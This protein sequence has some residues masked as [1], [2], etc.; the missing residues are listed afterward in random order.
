MKRWVFLKELSCQ[1]A[2]LPVSLFYLEE[3]QTTE[4]LWIK[5]MFSLKHGLYHSCLVEENVF[6]RKL[7]FKMN[8]CFQA[9]WYLGGR[10][11]STSLISRLAWARCWVPGQPGLHSRIPV[12]RTN[13]PFCVV[14]V[15]NPS[16]CEIE[17][18]GLSWLQDQTCQVYKDMV[19]HDN[20]K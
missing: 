4:C 17:T 3:I 18:G 12:S 7:Y 11:R 20:N 10:G 8:G 15:C 1:P 13:W 16:T 9:W 2:S 14:C 19:S 6:L 5:E